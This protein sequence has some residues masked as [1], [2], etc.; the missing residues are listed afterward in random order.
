MKFITRLFCASV[1]LILT[2]T[3]LSA[4]TIC[5]MHFDLEGWSL[6]YKTASGT[7]TIDCEN[8]QKAAVSITAKGGGPTAGKTE[9]R[10]GIGK[11][12]GVASIDDLFGLYVSGGVD[13]AAGR[14]ASAA[15]MTKGNVH[16]ALAGTGSGRQLGLSFG[17]F[18]IERK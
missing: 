16:L 8:G 2:S 9:I 13:A 17:K 3:N 11:F 6:F 14:A 5:T 4:D 7:G 12:T 15:V 10:D 18:V 1:L